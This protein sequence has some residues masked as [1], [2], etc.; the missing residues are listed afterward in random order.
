MRTP[1][2]VP[3]VLPSR[4]LTPALLEGPRGQEG[5][6]PVVVGT[7]VPCR[8]GEVCDALPLPG[9]RLIYPEGAGTVPPVLEG[10]PDASSDLPLESPPGT[11]SISPALWLR[12]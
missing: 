3:R 6:G 2:F 5:S 10:A 4:L 1:V 9:S 8:L 7:A 11:E 12:L